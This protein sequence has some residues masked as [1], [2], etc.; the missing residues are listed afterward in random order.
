VLLA[1]AE[2]LFRVTVGT[3][4]PDVGMDTLASLTQRRASATLAGIRG[5]HYVSTVVSAA[6]AEATTE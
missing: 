6:S 4:E 5:V 3:G 1:T 2:R